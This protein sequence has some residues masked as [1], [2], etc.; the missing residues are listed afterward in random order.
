MEINLQV[1]HCKKCN[2]Q[3]IPRVVPKMCP[4]CKTYYWNGKKEKEA[5]LEEIPLE[6]TT[7]L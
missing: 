2:H 3:W 1:L 7:L 5:H 6:E 4:R